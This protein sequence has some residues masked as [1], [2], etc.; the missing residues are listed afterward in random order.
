LLKNTLDFQILWKRSKSY[1]PNIGSE[2]G[3]FCLLVLMKQ[4]T[5]IFI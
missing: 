5:T 4:P 1:T 2:Q 3:F